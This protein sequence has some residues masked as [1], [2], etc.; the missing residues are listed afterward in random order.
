MKILFILILTCFSGVN[1]L[2]AQDKNKTD[3][4][5]HELRGAVE[6]VENYI[7]EY[8]SQGGAIIE[9]ERRWFTNS[10]TV[11]GDYSE[12][13]SYQAD[14]RSIINDYLYD[15]QGNNVECRDYPSIE[16]K[17]INK[18][19]KYVQKF[20]AQGDMIERIVTEPDGSSSVRFVY[21][22]DAKGNKIEYRYY[23]YTGVLGGTTVYTYNNNSELLSQI[24]F[25]GD[26]SLIWK[27]LYAVNDKGQTVEDKTYIGETL[28]YRESFAYDDKGRVIRQ[29]TSEF[30]TIPDTWTSHAPRPGKI[31]FIYDN[32]NER[33]IEKLEFDE[34]DILRFAGLAKYDEKGNQIEA[35]G[36][37][38]GGSFN[39]LMKVIDKSPAI[40]KKFLG[41]FRSKSVTR[42]EYDTQGNW[43]KKIRLDSLREDGE[44]TL[45]NGERRVISYY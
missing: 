17:N 24:Y 36:Y 44:P 16:D 18:Y 27:H 3:R 26:G 30:N 28:R 6:K 33:I 8:S 5:R 40:Q 31:I 42:Y 10:Y 22:Y 12:T 37:E 38:S 19:Q 7:I 23:N 2:T 32:E 11:K 43:T 13:I 25:G 14:G 41:N 34:K 35:V 1:S 15:N 9:K 45:R 39:D 20:D 4:E 29:D 21:K